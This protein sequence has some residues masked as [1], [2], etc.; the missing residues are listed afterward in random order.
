LYY[1]ECQTGGKTNDIQAT[2][3]RDGRENERLWLASSDRSLYCFLEPGEEFHLKYLIFLSPAM[4]AT[5]HGSSQSTLR[6]KSLGNTKLCTRFPWFSHLISSYLCK[7]WS[8]LG[9]SVCQEKKITNQ[10]QLSL[11][12]YHLDFRLKIHR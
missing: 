4:M 3:T 7:D 9:R 5:L 10:P 8:H 12:H 2:F 11:H 6:Q 1:L